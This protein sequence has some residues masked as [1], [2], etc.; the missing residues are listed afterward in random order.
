MSFAVCARTAVESWERDGVPS[1]ASRRLTVIADIVRVLRR[2]V[3]ESRLPAVVRRPAAVFGGH[4]LL[5][6]LREGREVDVLE[7]VQASFDWASGA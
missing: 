3:E 6:C 1:V 4:T 5:D 2:N 7:V